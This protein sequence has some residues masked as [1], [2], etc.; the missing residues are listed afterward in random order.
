MEPAPILEQWRNDPSS[1]AQRSRFDPG[2]ILEALRSDH[3]RIQERS[4]MEQATI[5]VQRRN[6]GATTCAGHGRASGRPNGA[7]CAEVER[8]HAGVGIPGG[9]VATVTKEQVAVH[10]V[11]VALAQ[12]QQVGKVVLP[13]WV[14]AHRNQVVGAHPG[15]APACRTS[16]VLLQETA[17]NAAPAAGVAPLGRMWGDGDATQEEH[18]H[19]GGVCGKTPAR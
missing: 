13:G 11:L 4:P 3:Q 10:A 6:N 9:P 15:A 1:M 12:G 8:I 7:G 18:C 16:G 19:G 2:V 14:H 17:C 5:Q